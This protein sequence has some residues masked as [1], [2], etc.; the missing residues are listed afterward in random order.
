MSVPFVIEALLVARRA[1]RD[2]A[3]ERARQ[4]REDMQATETARAAIEQRF[5]RT[6][7]LRADC[8]T[9]L[10]RLARDG[11]DA[12]AEHARTAEHVAMLGARADEIRFDLSRAEHAHAIARAQLEEAMTF[13]T[14]AQKRLDA[15]LERKAE[16]EREARN[17]GLRA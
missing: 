3:V 15:A 8:V 2:G 14:R 6:V 13:L 10:A 11:A 17:A 12:T 1:C 5:K 7:A 4:C 16:W 9:R